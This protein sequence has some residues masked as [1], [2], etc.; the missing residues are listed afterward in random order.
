MQDSS[1]EYLL[2]MVGFLLQLCLKLS[3]ANHLPV[4]VCR[5]EN[6]DPKEG[7]SNLQKQPLTSS[8][9]PLSY[10]QVEYPVNVQYI[11]KEIG[12]Q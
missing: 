3:F 9:L 12:K 5:K 6:A 2:V 8:K 11:H 10:C 7:C 4:P 1:K